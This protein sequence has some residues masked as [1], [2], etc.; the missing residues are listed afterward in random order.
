MPQDNLEHI[1]KLE[2]PLVVLLG[3]RTL[4]VLEVVKLVPGSII[5]LPKNADAALELRCNNR[6]IGCGH[7]VK[8]GEN[9]GLQLNFVGDL[10]T[11]VEALGPKA[12]DATAAESQDPAALAEALLA[13]QL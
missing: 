5:E 11:R 8:V 7:A 2:V 13:G 9:F 12:P 1:L 10:K 3:E 6:A 4:P